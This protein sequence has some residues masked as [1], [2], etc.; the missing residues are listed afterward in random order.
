VVALYVKGLRVVDIARKLGVGETTVRGHLRVAGMPRKR[1]VAPIWTGRAPYWELH[2]WGGNSEVVLG[3]KFCS[4]CGRWRLLLDFV[5]SAQRC[6]TCVLRAKRYYHH[7]ATPEQVELRRE[8]RRFAAEVRRRGNGVKP[9][10]FKRRQ[11]VIDQIERVCLPLEP[12]L[13]ELERYDDGEL[14]S[15]AAR[16]GVSP[17]ALYRYRYGESS[18]VRIDVADKLAV[19]MGTTSSLIWTDQW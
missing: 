1:D 4:G 19:A 5:H 3:R 7:H 10:E 11:T 14:T 17:R 2:T 12:L 16:A 13:V 8:A 15:L 18:T 6:E 9:R